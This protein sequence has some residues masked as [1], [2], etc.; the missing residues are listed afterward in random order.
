MERRGASSPIFMISIFNAM[1][2]RLAQPDLSSFFRHY[3]QDFEVFDRQELVNWGCP[4]VR[5][6]W[7]VREF[8]TGLARLGVNA[9]ACEYTLHMLLSHSTARTF[10]CDEKGVKEVS[11]QVA[12]DLLRERDAYQVLPGAIAK[13]G[14]VESVLATYEVD[15]KDRYSSNPKW[16]V[17][18]TSYETLTIQDATALRLLAHQIVAK[19]AG[20]LLVG[21]DSIQANGK[22][23][24]E[25]VAELRGEIH[26]STSAVSPASGQLF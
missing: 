8:G 10:V 14:A 21:A 12:E 22:D 23:I 13:L 1:A 19:A 20:S 26:A 5:Y 7:V 18:F 17:R 24:T 25:L 15:V 2:E 4:G 16:S 3:R 11:R 6:L 9:K